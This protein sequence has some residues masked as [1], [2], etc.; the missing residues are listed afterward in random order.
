MRVN[1]FSNSLIKPLLIYL[2]A[3]SVR[4]N[5]TLKS[6]PSLSLASAIYH[7]EYS[8]LQILWLGINHSIILMETPL[9]SQRIE[10]TINRQFFC[11]MGKESFPQIIRKELGYGQE[12][13]MESSST[14]KI[15][16]SLEL[17]HM[18]REER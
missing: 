11:L 15:T 12:I 10:I 8:I 2:L 7:R 5:S 3:L 17:F 6:I 9:N 13:P 16:F 18:I 4:Y 14:K 1:S